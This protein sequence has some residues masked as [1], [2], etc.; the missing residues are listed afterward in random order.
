M[1]GCLNGYVAPTTD[2]GSAATPATTPATTP[3]TTPA[4]KSNA[5]V[6]TSF[7]LNGQTSSNINATAITVIM[8]AGTNVASLIASFTTSPNAKVTLQGV[9]QVSG[10]TANSF[11]N[12]QAYV[13]TAEDG[14][15]TTTYTVTTTVAAAA[16]A[17]TKTLHT[18]VFN[19]INGVVNETA[20][21]AVVTLPFWNTAGNVSATGATFTFTGASVNPVSGTVRNFNAAQTYTITATDASTQAYTASV[22]VPVPVWSLVN[23]LVAT[24]Q[25]YTLTLL[26]TAP[27]AGNVLIAAGGDGATPVNTAAIYN[28]ATGAWTATPVMATGNRT[29]HTAT[30]LA[31]GDV[32]VAGGL[33]APAGAV[34]ADTLYSNTGNTW[35]AVS[36]SMTVRQSAAAVRLNNNTVLILGGC[37]NTDTAVSCITALNTSQIYTPGVA[38]T[39][40]AWGAAAVTLNV[41][42]IWPVA[43]VLADGR[44]LVTGGA[45]N[46]ATPV[47]LNSTEVFSAIAGTIGATGAAVGTVA[48]TAGPAMAAARVYHGAVLL[49]NNNVLICGGMTGAA[50]ATNSCDLFNPTTNTISATGAMGTARQ[51]FALTMLQNGKALA[52]GG[53]SAGFGNTALASCES[54]DPT[55]G[56]WTAAANMVAPRYQFSQVQ[57]TDG[58]ILSPGGVTTGP[59]AT[60][61]VETL[62]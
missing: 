33:T 55:T 26:S 18:F 37:P 32:L 36:G 38:G 45:S 28:A 14:V 7:V 49:P 39:I 4:A 62:R 1:Q 30:L 3:T 9:A 52:C 24:R 10:T 35:S 19:G 48:A 34:L 56:V 16:T 40:G 46:A 23:P 8:P 44:V 13:V 57:L 47:S 27:N 54:Y 59:A 17:S 42:R 2:T 6:M 5:A 25:D 20:K 12:A 41:A 61:T 53:S 31:T 60:A 51:S 58:R 50:T 43:T 11:A 29:N 22:V 21:T 15:T